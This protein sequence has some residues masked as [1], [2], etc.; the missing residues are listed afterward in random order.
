MG[1]PELKFSIHQMLDDTEDPEV[2]ALVY[3]LLKKFTLL[4]HDDNV[5]G[6]NENLVRTS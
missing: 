6:G 3:A 4:G 2:L 1:A 5:V